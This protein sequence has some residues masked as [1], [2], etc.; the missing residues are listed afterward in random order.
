MAND[1]NTRL[2]KEINNLLIRYSRESESFV[3]E[4]NR[5]VSKYGDDIYPQLIFITAHLEFTQR[6]AKKHYQHVLLHW[7]T[8]CKYQK[9]NIDFRVALLDYF[10]DVNKRIKNPKIIEIRVFQKTQ[11][12]TFI[13]E[14]TQL[15][16]YR[17]FMKALEAEILR[18]NRYNAP[19]S[20]LICDVDDF[21]YYND[22]N[23]HLSGNKAL[24]KLAKIIKK[25]VRD[26]D[27]PSRYG[28]EEFAV[29]LPETNK[30]GGYVISE[31]MRK[32]TERSTFI[33]NGMQPL[34]KFSISGGVATLNVDAVTAK[35]LITKADQALY[36]AKSRGKNQTALYED[37]RRGTE[38]IDTSFFGRLRLSTDVGDV[39]EVRNIS[40]YGLRFRYPNALAIGT[41]LKLFLDFP[42][43]R[44]SVPC[45]AKLVRVKELKE[46]K[47]YELGA[48]IFQIREN[49]KKVL[50]RFLDVLERN[51]NRAK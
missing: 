12:E 48:R 11:E 22:I 5:L 28:G 32:N 4:I 47:E 24:K 41:I 16:N 21:K 2:L 38:R 42:N 17:Y 3:N 46:G 30:E 10:I 18:A 9:R 39:I 20:L 43:R 40:E 8:M 37:E 29:I 1:S 49:D 27:I 45:K 36:R 44:T 23:G 51:P 15:Y 35:E 50:K 19:L 31:R 13:D 34:K 26:V 14:L 25:S 6:I 33:K 7:K